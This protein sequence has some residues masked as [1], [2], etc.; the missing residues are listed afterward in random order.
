VS[1][2]LSE[3]IARG[4]SPE[5]R[6]L[7]RYSCVSVISVIVSVVVLAITHGLLLWSA[8]A[9]NVTATSVATVPSYE[10]NRRWAWGK[11]G[12]SHLWKEV[13]PF[14]VLSFIGLAFSTWW[15]VAA[16]RLAKSH[17]LS[18][19]AETLVVELAVLSAFGI[20]WIGK[21]II[22]NKILFAGHTDD[23]EPSLDG[24]T[25]VPL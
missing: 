25:G 17:H 23:L 2:A 15:A 1:A 8:F 5:G 4:R 10:L 20:L 3:L 16:S 6:K 19:P 13:V 24:R 18:H 22:F 11:S 7:I 14:W 9:S 12:K 21:F